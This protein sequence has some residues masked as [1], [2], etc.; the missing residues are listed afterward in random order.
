MSIP[1]HRIFLI[2]IFAVACDS[3]PQRRAESAAVPA[4]PAP[5]VRAARAA[6]KSAMPDHTAA[7]PCPH[8]GRWA[9]CSVERRLRQ[10]GFVVRRVEG[11]SPQ[12]AGF[13]VPPV[14]YALG[15]ARLEV[16]IYPDDAAMARDMA[17][18]D[19]IRASPIGVAD[20]WETTPLLVRSGNL[21]AVFL[22]ENQRQAERLALALTAGAPQPGS[23]R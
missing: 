8:T 9:L 4:V 20:A 15:R 21:A 13:S 5:A 1:R 10:A 2:W 11:A 3:S 7:S 23:P 12:R 14:V 22:T 16:F 17:K 6:E 18:I 19:T